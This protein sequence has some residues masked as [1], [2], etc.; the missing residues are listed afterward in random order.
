VIKKIVFSAVLSVPFVASVTAMAQGWVTPYG[1]PALY[2]AA[3]IFG[4][5]PIV[6][7]CV[8]LTGLAVR[9]DER[10]SGSRGTRTLY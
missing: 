3:A 2:S 9:F 5:I 4:L 10:A 7:G 1:S 6:T 8:L